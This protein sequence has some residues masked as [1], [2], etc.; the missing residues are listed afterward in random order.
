MQEV[1]VKFK[2]NNTVY[3][4]VVDKISNQYSIELS[5]KLQNDAVF[6]LPEQIDKPIVVGSKIM[7][8][9]RVKDISGEKEIMTL[10]VQTAQTLVSDE[11]EFDI[12]SG[13]MA[14]RML[15]ALGWEKDVDVVKKRSEG[16]V[17][18]YGVCVDQ[19]EQLGVFIELEKIAENS[20]QETIMSIQ[21][22][23]KSF[24]HAL[25]L[26]GEISMVPYDTQIKNLR[27]EL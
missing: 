21:E 18:G 10:K 23:M 9:R 25:E 6:L 8:I 17:S 11:Y 22:E 24:L 2:L 13:D 12:S 20:D 14:E 4:D 15:V 19:V 26:D 16:L 3:G 5:E 27:R 7:R 1:E